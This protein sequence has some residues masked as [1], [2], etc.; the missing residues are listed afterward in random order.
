MRGLTLKFVRFIVDKLYG[1]QVGINGVIE[2]YC[3]SCGKEIAR[4]DKFCPHCGSSFKIVPESSSELEGK[5]EEAAPEETQKVEPKPTT[6]AGK[7]RIPIWLLIVAPLV[8][9]LI[10][11]GVVGGV[12][13]ARSGSELFA[14]IKS[15]KLSSSNGGSLN[16]ESVPLNQDVTVKVKYLAQFPQDGD[17]EL[18]VKLVD[19]DG[20]EI[21]SDDKEC[22]SKEETQTY[23][24]A[25]TMDN[26]LSGEKLEIVATLKVE[27]GSSK[28][29]DEDSLAYVAEEAEEEDTSGQTIEDTQL[30]QAFDQ[31]YAR[32]DEAINAVNQLISDGIDGSGLPDILEKS[33]FLLEHGTTMQDYMGESDSAMFYAN[34]A[35]NECNARREAH[36]RAQEE[37]ARQR[38]S[39]PQ[40]GPSNIWVTCYQCDGWGGWYDYDDLGY[41]YWVTCGTCGGT[42][43]VLVPND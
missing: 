36:A 15:I 12:L 16:L 7:K 27:A 35:I 1:T 42:G 13:W 19:N 38:R 43:S 41:Q 23:E 29:D 2:M 40:P 24:E 11:G 33:L 22:E 9:I 31:A 21:L 6:G 4:V 39:Q 34:Y 14:E 10:I 28:V 20:N 17:G 8:L 18:V 5:T 32:T 30:K 3:Q 25:L 37:A 26:T